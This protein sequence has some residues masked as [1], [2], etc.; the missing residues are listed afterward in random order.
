MSETVLFVSTICEYYDYVKCVN[1]SLKYCTLC[2]CVYKVLCGGIYV[3]TMTYKVHSKVLH[4][5]SL[6]DCNNDFVT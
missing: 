1:I 4:S 3:N 2:Q 5:K 6:S